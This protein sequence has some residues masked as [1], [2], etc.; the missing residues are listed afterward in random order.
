MGIGNKIKEFE[1]LPEQTLREFNRVFSGNELD[2]NPSVEIGEIVG[3]AN[4]RKVLV[5]GKEVKHA[6]NTTVSLNDLIPMD[7]PLGD[8]SRDKECREEAEEE[9]KKFHSNGI[10]TNAELENMIMTEA[11]MKLEPV[12]YKLLQYFRGCQSPYHTQDEIGG[13]LGITTR[14]LRDVMKR[15]EQKGIITTEIVIVSVSRTYVVI[16]DEWL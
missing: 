1:E 9:R 16:N 3:P 10:T 7:A 15:M 14:S 8:W 12:E 11:E 4:V 2:F 13:R 6:F 5:D